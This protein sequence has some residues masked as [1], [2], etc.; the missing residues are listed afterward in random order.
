MKKITFGLTESEYDSLTDTA[1]QYQPSREISVGYLLTTNSV[2]TIKGAKQGYLTGVLY[3]APHNVAGENICASSTAECRNACLWSSGQLGMPSG[4]RATIARTLFLHHRPSEFFARLT[5]E[6]ASLERRAKRQGKKLAIRLNG[7]SDIPW[8]ASKHDCYL[9][10][11]VE[12]FP[13]VTF[14]DY[15]KHIG[16][17]VNGY[18]AK[19]GLDDYRLTF[20]YSG[21]NWAACE[22]ALNDGVNVA[23]AFADELPETY[24]GYR[25][26]DGDLHD[27]RFLDE[28]GVIVG[29][30]YKLPKMLNKSGTLRAHNVPNFV[31]Q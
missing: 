5:Q 3:L 16:R 29:L 26:I 15:T 27:L 18:R 12:L 11:V 6:I 4:R 14:Y 31:I 10:S 9:Q 17:C 24:N 30:R 19:K 20:S 1:K 8:E 21:K 23:M 13:E 2:K 7:T 22:M 25:V 28:P